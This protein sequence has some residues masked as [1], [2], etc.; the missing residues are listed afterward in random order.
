VTADF[1]RNEAK[2]KKKKWSKI[3]WKNCK[4]NLIILMI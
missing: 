2:K 4:N 1:N 3:S